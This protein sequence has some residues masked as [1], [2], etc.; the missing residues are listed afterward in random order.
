MEKDNTDLIKQKQAKFMAKVGASLPEGDLV[1]YDDFGIPD[2]A[3]LADHEQ[4]P[5]QSPPPQQT[6]PKRGF[7]PNSS[8]DNRPLPPQMQ[9][10]QGQAPRKYQHPVV[11]KLLGK[12]GL[13]KVKPK[14]LEVTADGTT[15]N[16]RMKP[17]R[18]ALRIWRRHVQDRPWRCGRNG[19]LPASG[20]G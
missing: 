15:I 10:P 9:R 7:M 1:G 5:P 2:P 19:S 12:F 13:N 20:G 3:A 4:E 6:A 11:I 18:Y 14:S 16:V 8:P 17:M